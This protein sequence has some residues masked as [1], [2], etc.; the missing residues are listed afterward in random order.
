MISG[1]VISLL[2]SRK[3]EN[4]F[5]Y[6]K[7]RFFRLF[8]LFFV[9]L[10]ISAALNPIF[11][12]NLLSLKSSLSPEFIDFFIERSRLWRSNPGGYLIAATSLL[13]GLIPD[14]IL[15]HA[16]TS[17]LGQG[18]SLSL[19]WQFYLVA[20]ALVA[21]LTPPTK[22]IQVIGSGVVILLLKGLYPTVGYG[23]AL[24]N[25]IEYFV[26]GILSF[27]AFRTIA[28]SPA[29]QTSANSSQDASHAFPWFSSCCALS[30]LALLISRS[31]AL[32]P[33]AL[34]AVVLV[35]SMEL[36]QSP[37]SQAVRF[38]LQNPISL[39]LGKISYSLYLSHMIVLTIAQAVLIQL[40]LHNNLWKNGIA[41]TFATLAGSVILSHFTYH[42]IELKGA[43]LGKPRLVGPKSSR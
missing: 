9:M 39:Y 5:V 16:S 34:W 3:S 7:R 23:A 13:H 11:N 31:E 1:F 15:P 29:N 32:L 35:Q 33:L 18:W 24:P 38:L 19:E 26:I 8:P 2:L 6:L 27:F 42:S 37:L 10:I 14:S 22:A 12:Q 17:F 36:E 4:Y 40:N 20:P 41:L 21:M 28:A 30:L 25:H 43:S